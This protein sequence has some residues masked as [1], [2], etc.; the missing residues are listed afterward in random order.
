RTPCFKICYM[1][2]REFGSQSISVHEPQ[3]PKKWHVENDQL[4][5]YFRRMEPRKPG[6]LTC[7]SGTLTAENE[8]AY[9]STQAPLLPYGN[10]G[11]TFLP[12]HLIVHQRHC[13]KG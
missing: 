4:P 6:I 9:E 12:D 11:Q 13:R 1:C 7:G 10:C 5:S 3:C 8:S 2:G